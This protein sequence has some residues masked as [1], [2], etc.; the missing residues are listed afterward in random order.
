MKSLIFN[1][2]GKKLTSSCKQVN[3]SEYL[4]LAK[5]EIKKAF[6]YSKMEI[7]GYGCVELITAKTG[8]SGA[9]YWFKCPICKRKA[10]II[11]KHPENRL[12][13]CRKCLNLEYKSRRYKGMPESLAK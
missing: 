5:N 13:G 9:R 8:I 2:L 11:Y 3:I 10:G 1:N 7:E 12:I 6:L 4:K